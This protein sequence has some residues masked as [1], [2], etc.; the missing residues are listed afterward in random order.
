[1]EDEKSLTG[2]E[3]LAIITRMINKAK[4]EYEE[5]GVSALLWGSVITICSLVSFTG[6]QLD[7]DSLDYI[8][9]LPIGAVAAQ[10]II[11]VRESRRKKYRS[12]DDATMGGIW[13]SF[14]ISMFLFSFYASKFN[15]PHANVLFLIV[16]GIPTFATGISRNFKPMIWGGIACWLLAVAA[17][18]TKP[19]YTLLYT[20]VAA[21]LAWFIPGL[22]LRKRYVK[23]RSGNV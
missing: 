9:F 1:M 21:Q 8:W 15:I 23:A 13:I 20:A 4:C 11:A 16:Y 3:S 18:Y 17:M 7:I 5:T 12:Y 19:P 6:R 22:I 14:G 10:V 2:E